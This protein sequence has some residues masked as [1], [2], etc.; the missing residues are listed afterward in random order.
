MECLH[1][2]VIDGYHKDFASVFELAGVDVA[3]DVVFAACWAES[4]RDACG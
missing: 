2:G 3:R 1:E 4:C